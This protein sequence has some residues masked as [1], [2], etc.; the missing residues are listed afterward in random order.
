MQEQAGRSVLCGF[1][2]R[3][4][5]GTGRPDHVITARSASG[6]SPIVSP[7][8]SQLELKR[9]QGQNTD[10]TAMPYS[11]TLTLGGGHFLLLHT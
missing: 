10:P 1:E 9:L 4:R 5:A 8:A 2:M 11:S 3:L 7:L 6:D